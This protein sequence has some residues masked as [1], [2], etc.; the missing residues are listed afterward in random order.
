MLTKDWPA[1]NATPL[2]VNE[3][4][5]GKDGILTARKGFA[6]LSS[7]SRKP[8]SA[9]ANVYSVSSKNVIALSNP[10]VGSFTDVTVIVNVCG[11]LVA[12]PLSRSVTVTVATPLEFAAGV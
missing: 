11:G 1:V 10:S 6:G 9:M 8:K 3:P 7:G 12:P 5:L 4:L 2:V